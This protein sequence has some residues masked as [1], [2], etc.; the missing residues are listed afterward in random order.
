MP[1]RGLGQQ[2]AGQQCPH[3]HRQPGHLHQ[4]CRAQ[5]HQQCCSRHH[6]ARL[7]R[8]QNAEQPIEQPTPGH[9]QADDAGQ[10]DADALPALRCGLRIAAS[11]H[12]GYDRQQR[13]DQ[14]IFE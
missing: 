5:H 10:T 11:S 8:S 14:Q 4:Q 3:R 1:E 6:L 12:P 13:H 2:H 9:Q 7:G